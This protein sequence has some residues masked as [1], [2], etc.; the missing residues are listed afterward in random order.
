MLNFKFMIHFIKSAESY[1]H[2]RSQIKFIINLTFNIYFYISIAWRI[3]YMI[4]WMCIVDRGDGRMN[5]RMDVH[6]CGTG[7]DI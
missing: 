4:T 2:Y 7:A 3:Y 1:V 6:G 5:D